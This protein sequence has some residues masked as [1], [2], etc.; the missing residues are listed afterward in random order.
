MQKKI[1]ENRTTSNLLCQVYF[2]HFTDTLSAINEPD[3]RWQMV[4]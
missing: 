2:C 4:R 3:N 1:I